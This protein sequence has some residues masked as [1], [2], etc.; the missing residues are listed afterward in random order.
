MSGLGLEGILSSGAC[1]VYGS[2]CWTLFGDMFSLLLYGEE[3][4]VCDLKLH[5]FQC[6]KLQLLQL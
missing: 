4:G 1:K 3:S 6:N 2:R 5:R